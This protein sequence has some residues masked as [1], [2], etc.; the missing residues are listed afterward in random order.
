MGER[1]REE[2]EKA[3]DLLKHC[4]DG[5]GYEILFLLKLEFLEK[6]YM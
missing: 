6:N 4:S 2:Q 1:G 5:T 3:M